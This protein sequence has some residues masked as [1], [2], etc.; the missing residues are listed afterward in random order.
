VPETTVSAVADS[1]SLAERNNCIHAK[2]LN[3]R[4]LSFWHE[5]CDE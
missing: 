4:E 5:V 3:W 2:R 1:Y